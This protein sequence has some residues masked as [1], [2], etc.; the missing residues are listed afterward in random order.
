MIDL[1]CCTGISYLFRPT[2]L[3]YAVLCCAAAEALVVG[4]V[5]DEKQ[6]PAIILDR[7]VFHPQGGGQPS[8]CGEYRVLRTYRCAIPYGKV[9][10][11]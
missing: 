1:V 7:T 5:E 9:D 2:L 11:Y 3:C 10:Y 8:D 6:G 4:V